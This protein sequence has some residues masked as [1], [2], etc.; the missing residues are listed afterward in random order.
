[1]QKKYQVFISSTFS[2]LSDVRTSLVKQVL[3]LGHIPSGMESFLAADEEQMSYIKKVIDQCDY[4]LLVVGGRYG[5]VDEEG[6]SY[7]EREFDYAVAEK[8]VIL[9]SICEDRGSL[10]SNLVDT[11][12]EKLEKLDSFIAKIKT[13]RLVIFWKNKNDISV[14]LA[15]SLAKTIESTPQVGW[16][17]GDGGDRLDLL[18][19]INSLRSEN[20]ELKNRL[21][22]QNTEDGI[23]WSMPD[24]EQV[25]FDPER[26][27]NIFYLDINGF[28]N[29]M[30]F[31][32]IRIMRGIGSRWFNFVDD[33]S[34]SEFCLELLPDSETFLNSE[35]RVLAYSIEEIKIILAASG[36]LELSEG[37]SR[38]TEKGKKSM[39]GW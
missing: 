12:Q 22:T 29:F 10:Q 11:D 17:R 24:E 32:V 18:E 30:E 33:S 3:D 38:L 34:L 15:L 25:L 35:V 5:S 39:L 16:V 27:V 9:A 19:Q 2:D 6:V 1:M 37:K 14:Q 31:S 8:K 4:Y 36:M 28:R 20:S 26:R 21:A 23:P 7:T 13:G